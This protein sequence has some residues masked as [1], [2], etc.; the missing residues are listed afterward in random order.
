[1]CMFRVAKFYVYIH[2]LT[3]LQTCKPQNGSYNWLLRHSFLLQFSRF[4]YKPRL[5]HL[6]S[7]KKRQN[8]SYNWPL[9]HSFLF[10]FSVFRLLHIYN[11]VN[12]LFKYRKSRRNMVPLK[13]LYY[14]INVY[15]SNITIT[16]NFPVTRALVTCFNII[17][18]SAHLQFSTQRLFWKLHHSIC[19]NTRVKTHLH[20]SY[21][22]HSKLPLFSHH[23]QAPAI[24]SLK[25]S[26][27]W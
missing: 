14:A 1:M 7:K 21:W 15:H 5:K 27:K 17:F 6:Q 26:L 24:F 13:L 25:F 3:H 12:L 19:L 20:F 2:S 16:T 23:L 10:Y 18:P 4:S 11:L 22:L 8:G 9:W